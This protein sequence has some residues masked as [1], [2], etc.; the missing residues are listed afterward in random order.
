MGGRLS[1][2]GTPV[3]EFGRGK[4]R[5]LREI[6]RAF[7]AVAT[8]FGTR[9]GVTEADYLDLL[10]D[11]SHTVD[12]AALGQRPASFAEQYLVHPLLEVLG[13]DYVT[14]A[15]VRFEPVAE[16]GPPT[17]ADLRITNTS[18]TRRDRLTG[19]PWGGDDGDGY[20]PEV[21]GQSAGLNAY[22]EAKAAIGEKYVHPFLQVDVGIA[23]DGFDWGV[24]VGVPGAETWEEFSLRGFATKVAA[25]VYEEPVSPEEYADADDRLVDFLEF[26]HK[27]NLERALL[28]RDAGVVWG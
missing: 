7:S 23:T 25:H 9:E 26:L 24:Y 12:G 17:F 14:D 8:E 3:D 18:Y 11:P 10:C 4:R 6:V 1:I 15:A 5:T 13:Y 21:V 22:D 28:Q 20:R 2:H 27:P 19:A 16:P